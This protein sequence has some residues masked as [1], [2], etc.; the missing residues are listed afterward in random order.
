MS[1]HAKV[2]KVI[3]AK[4]AEYAAQFDGNM[5]LAYAALSG[6]M[7]ATIVSVVDKVEVY[8]DAKLQQLVHE[9]VGL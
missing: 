1:T 9:S 8:G 4:L 7:S 2:Q 3:D 5:T 6:W